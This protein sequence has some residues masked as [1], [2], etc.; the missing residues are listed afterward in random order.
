[1]SY[2]AFRHIW[3]FSSLPCIH[4][5]Y[6][7]RYST[8]A[9]KPPMKWTSL[10]RRQLFPTDDESSGTR[11]T[12]KCSHSFC[13]LVH[14]APRVCTLSFIPLVAAEKEYTNAACVCSS[15]LQC[16]A[17]VWSWNGIYTLCTVMCYMMSFE[18]TSVATQECEWTTI[19][20]RQHSLF[21]IVPALQCWYPREGHPLSIWEGAILAVNMKLGNTSTL[22]CNAR[23]FL[24]GTVGNLR[25]MHIL[26]NF[27]FMD[28]RYVVMHACKHVS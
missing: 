7:I 15:L 9:V 14:T 11:A 6:P 2:I 24:Q 10:Q 20:I 3:N 1:M 12:T 27:Y 8:A 21:C 25:K 4:I 16:G 13:S 19:D 28:A 23:F 5:V 18:L 17:P 26:G 22:L